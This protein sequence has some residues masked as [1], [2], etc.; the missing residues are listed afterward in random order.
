MGGAAM[1]LSS[2]RQDKGRSKYE[3]VHSVRTHKGAKCMYQR[4]DDTGKIV[5]CLARE[6]MAVAGDTFKTTS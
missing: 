6:L 3:L 5:V 1:L 2:T 4:E